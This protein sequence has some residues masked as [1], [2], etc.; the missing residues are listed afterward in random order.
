MWKFPLYEI[1]S[2]VD[3]NAMEERFDWFKDMREVEQDEVWHAEG[4]VMIHTKM[5]CEA[6][7]GLPEF[8]E[9]SEQD[10]HI[11]FAGALM[12]DIE[13]RSTTTKEFKDGRMCVVAPSHARKGEYTAR[14]V[15]YKDLECPFEI[16]EQICKIVRYHGIPLWSVE[17]DDAEERVIASSLV[18]RNSLLAMIAKADILGRTCEDAK[19]Q[20]EKIDFFEMLCKEQECWDGPKDFPSNLAR[21]KYLNEGGW[22]YFD[23]FDDKKFNVYMMCALP[24]SGKDT[25]INKEL[26]L[27]VLSLDDMRREKGISP[28]DKKGNGKIIQEGKE[29]A[30]QFMRNKE[31]FVFNA[32]NITSDMR[33]KWISLFEEYGGKINIIYI[34][35]PYKTLLS[36]NHNREYKVPEDKLDKLV[37]KLEIP[38]YKEAH[39]I[40]FIIKNK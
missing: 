32:T 9:L 2:E 26:N 1:G 11:M 16:R 4:N 24:G 29:R 27:P 3:W 23:P 18:V 10:K 34:E 28:T 14:Q 36:Q 8:Q 33:G 20:L 6:L 22:P 37:R 12:H 25:Y 40:K 31:D 15:L 7:V 17:D 35:V 19:E 5:V 21:Y 30:K 39:N 13:K 38:N